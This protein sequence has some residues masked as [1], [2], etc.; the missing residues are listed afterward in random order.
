M[1]CAKHNCKKNYA[2][3]KKKIIN[4]LTG[5]ITREK[6]CSCGFLFKTYEIEQNKFANLEKIPKI[7]QNFKFN[8]NEINRTKWKNFRIHRYAGLRLFDCLEVFNKHIQE[9]GKKLNTSKN[10]K[11]SE[12]ESSIFL[13]FYKKNYDFKKHNRIT[14]IGGK[15]YLNFDTDPEIDKLFKKY[16]ISKLLKFP[17]KKNTVKRC[18]DF[19][20]D[21]WKVRHELTNKPISDKKIKDLYRKELN[22]YYHSVCDFIEKK[23]FNQ[24]EYFI[25]KIPELKKY[26]HQYWNF[27]TIVR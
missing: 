4:K 8:K 23:P 12:I 22:E 5:V 10:K 9:I 19:D 14:K 17:N 26:W 20:I 1:E 15:S 11:I 2:I 25:K 16:K 27:F 21:Y 24:K 6:K 18:I 13:D 3:T 7:K